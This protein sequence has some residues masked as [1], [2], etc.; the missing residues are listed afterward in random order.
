[1][2]RPTKNTKDRRMTGTRV[3]PAQR[4]EEEG[5][6]KDGQRGRGEEEE[7]PFSYRKGFRIQWLLASMWPIDGQTTCPSTQPP[8]QYVYINISNWN[9]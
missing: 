1:M 6:R 7:S 5:D 2:K 3:Q 4:N 8:A 9:K